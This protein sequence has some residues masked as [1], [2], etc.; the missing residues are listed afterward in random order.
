[1]LLSVARF[2]NH[3]SIRGLCEIV[4][5]FFSLLLFTDAIIG[6]LLNSKSSRGIE[7]RIIHVLSRLLLLSFIS[8]SLCLVL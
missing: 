2:H 8:L 5:P 6:F 1:M 7:V 3:V 4:F